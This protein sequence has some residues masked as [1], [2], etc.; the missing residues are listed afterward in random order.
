MTDKSSLAVVSIVIE[1]GTRHAVSMTHVFSLHHWSL[2]LEPGRADC[3]TMYTDVVAD[4]VAL[5]L[6]HLLLVLSSGSLL[7]QT[8]RTWLSTTT[9]QTELERMGTRRPLLTR[10]TMIALGVGLIKL[11]VG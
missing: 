6:L 3:T 4:E 1:Y 5:H 8:V 2:M 11:L 10:L 9:C 7:S